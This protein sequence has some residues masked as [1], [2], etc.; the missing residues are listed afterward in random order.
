MRNLLA[1]FLIVIVLLLGWV[2]LPANQYIPRALL[3]TYPGI[4]DYPLFYNRVVEAADPS[5]WPVSEQYH[6]APLPRLLADSQ[7]ELGTVAFVVIQDSAL[8]FEHYN[9]K[10]GETSLSNSFSMAKSIVSLLIGIAIEEGKIKGVEQ[11]VSDFLPEYGTFQGKTLTIRHLLTM[12]AGVDWNESYSGL[13]GPTTAAYYGG[14]LPWL[15]KRIKQIR[16]PGEKVLY[17]SG[18]TQLLGFIVER[19]TGETLSDYASQKLWTPIQ[20]EQSALWSLDH[21]DGAEKAYCCF[22]SNARD[23][24]RFGQ[25]VLNR[26]KWNGIRVVPARYLEAATHPADDLI[27]QYDS[28]PNR[29][30]GYQFW[31]YEYKGMQIPF[32]R[33]MLG[34]YVFVIP[35]WNAVVV[36]LGE[37]N[38]EERDENHYPTDIAIWLESAEEILKRSAFSVQATQKSPAS[39]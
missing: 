15:M 20:A 26:G 39:Q 14:D 4:D 38:R 7:E 28:L 36:R 33:G 24:A 35:E 21:K 27:S 17:Q 23:F 19:A 9:G 3:Y 32:M 5:S 37:R 25:L 8:L 31:I 1:F 22:N 10:Y 13:I 29:L 2:L 11:P 12:S 34:Q 18:V 30:Y 16:K 6:T